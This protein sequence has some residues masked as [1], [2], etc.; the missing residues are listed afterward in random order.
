MAGP[1]FCVLG[2]VYLSR[3]VIQPL[4]DFIPL[5]IHLRIPDQVMRIARFFFALSTSLRQL[6]NFYQNL[7][8]DQLIPYQR[9][10]PYI[11][12]FQLQERLVPF[13]YINELLNDDCTRTIWKAKTT[14][15]DTECI[16]IV[17]KFVSRYNVKAHQICAD[18][19]YAPNLLYCS[20][21]NEAK[22]LGGLKMIIMKYVDGI[23]LDKIHKD[24]GMSNNQAILHDVNAAIQLLHDHNLVFA[25]LH[26]PNIMIVDDGQHA[27]LIDF[28]WCGTHDVDRY[29]PSM[30][31]KLPWPPGADPCA[32]LKKEYDVYWLYQLREYLK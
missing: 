6:N 2:A 13:T 26:A 19:G 5:T 14:D 24:G 32:I 30:N 23:S 10:F 4:T 12:Q 15:T 28:D 9:F 21:D 3:V 17:V 7:N 20:D 11:R 31:S 8:F 1:W 18:N 29:P 25:D 27:K 16:M 22:K